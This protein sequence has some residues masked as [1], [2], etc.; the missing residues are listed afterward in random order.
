MYD[1]KFMVH[2]VPKDYGGYMLMHN[3]GL[4]PLMLLIILGAAVG[5]DPL[6]KYVLATPVFVVLGRISY[7]QC[8]GGPLG[9][10]I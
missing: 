4:L 8:L 10:F 1:P 6:A 7:A 2:V 9:Y 5:R 3:G